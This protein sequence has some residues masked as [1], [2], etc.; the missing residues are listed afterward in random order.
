L[1]YLIDWKDDLRDC[2]SFFVF[3]LDGHCYICVLWIAISTFVCLC[4]FN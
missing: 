4:S 3:M 1:E 2:A